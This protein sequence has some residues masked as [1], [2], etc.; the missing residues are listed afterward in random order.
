MHKI[1]D[2]L[3]ITFNTRLFLYLVLGFVI[4]T[5]VGTVSHES[6]HYIAAKKLG[7]GAKLGYQSVSIDFKERFPKLDSLYRAD[8][9]KILSEENSPEKEYF[10]N[11][12][13]SLSNTMQSEYFI[14]TLCAPLQTMATGTIGFLILWF[15]RKKIW[16]KSSLS[17]TDW[18]WILLGFFW[19]RQVANILVAIAKYLLTGEISYKGDEVKISTYLFSLKGDSSFIALNSVGII[20]GLIGSVLLAY[21]TFCII[22]K[23]QR[24]TFIAA[25]IVG[26]AIGW[27]VWME[28]LGPVILP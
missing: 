10:L 9:E 7:Y 11:Y 3:P 28:T 21:I 14:F 23:K 8:E 17:V 27:I 26:S 25:G 5:I 22:P 16:Q 15:N 19:S 13:N 6:A 4:A 12:R 24:F 18:I 20:T 2:I 1:S